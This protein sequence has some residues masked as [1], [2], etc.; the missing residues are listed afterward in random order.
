MGRPTVYLKSGGD[1]MLGKP[2]PAGGSYFVDQ[3]NHEFSRD[4]EP[5]RGR[6][7]R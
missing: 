2:L 3:Y 5:L 7:R 1:Y 6:L 4:I